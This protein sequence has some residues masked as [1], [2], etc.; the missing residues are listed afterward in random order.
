MIFASNH[1]MPKQ[2]EIEILEPLLVPLWPNARALG[3]RT[4]SSAWYAA[5]KGFIPVVRLGTRLM[6]ATKTLERMTRD[7]GG[8]AA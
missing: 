7:P 1:N 8:E 2:K 5:N 3:Y 6:L 4:R